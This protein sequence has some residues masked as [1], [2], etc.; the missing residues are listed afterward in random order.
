MSRPHHNDHNQ[1][2]RG[3]KQ[4]R[5]DG[6]GNGHNQP[7]QQRIPG[8]TECV[9]CGRRDF[10]TPMVRTRRG[11]HLCAH[12]ITDAWDQFQS[13]A[14]TAAGTVTL[15]PTPRLDFLNR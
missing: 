9:G 14:W 7:K 3:Q 1:Q 10:E 12:C 11:P 13:G 2:Y 15:D 8:M 4:G 5:P 6:Q